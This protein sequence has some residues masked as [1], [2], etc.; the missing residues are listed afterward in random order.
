MPRFV[1]A[2]ALLLACAVAAAPVSA[3]ARPGDAKPIRLRIPAEATSDAL[4]SLA[5]EAG[6]SLGGDVGACQGTSRPLSGRHSLSGALGHLLAGSDCSFEIIDARTV[7]IRRRSPALVHAPAASPTVAPPAPPTV[8]GE[9]VV[10]A[11]RRAELAGRTP[12]AITAIAG[13]MLEQTGNS[14]ISD[15]G[16]MVAGMTVTNLGPGRNK[17]ILRGLSDGTFTGVTQSTVALYLDDVPVT[18][19]APDPDL[20]LIDVDRVEVMR[21]PQGTL[22]GGGSIG[23]IVRIV[24]RKP[25]VDEVSGSA[26]SSLSVTKNGGLNTDLEATLNLPVAPGRVGVRA[27]AYREVDSGYI[28]DVALGLKHANRGQRDGGRL[29]VRALINQDW[30]VQA[31]VVHQSINTR[32]TQYLVGGT[33]SLQ[34]ANQVREPHDNDFDEVYATVN[35]SGSW[36]RV[37]WASAGL[38]HN[39]D[40]RYDATP[41]L[42]TFGVTSGVGAYDDDRT[43]ELLV[44]EITI[45]SPDHGRFRWLAGA[46]GSVGDSHGRFTL[47]VMGDPPPLYRELRTD[48]VD[49]V[50][51]YG[52]ASYDLTRKLNVTAGARW[53]H[54]A[55]ETESSVTQAVGARMFRDNSDS[56]GVSPKISVLYRLNAR[57]LVYGQIAEGYRAGG[58]NTGG[59][60]GQAFDGAPGNPARE[61]A[62][63]ELWNY[64]LGAKL[65]LLSDRLQLRVAGFYAQWSDIQTD[66]FLPSGLPY[67]VNVGDGANRGLELELAWRPLRA[68]DV[69]AAALINDP[70]LTRLNPAFAARRDAGLPGVPRGS[71]SLAVDYTRP[72]WG[73]LDLALHGQLAY[74]GRSRL[75]FDAQDQMGN[76]VTGALSAGVESPRW[77]IRAFVDNPLDSRANTFAFGG[78]FLL[79]RDL[80]R[81]PLRPR[82][83]G[84][85]L[86]ARF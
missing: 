62:P 60:I 43:I 13:D 17:V 32:D 5:L 37:T 58:F 72:L 71:A 68:L 26:S 45:A 82:T 57:A 18:Y 47:G 75:T 40:S 30:S 25:D 27:S 63:D 81:T 12:Y 4:L 56:T 42:P 23:G 80:V 2:E 79:G 65:R 73:D 6:V 3:A 54:F 52:E 28:D 50:A 67:T 59:P 16:G 24:T 41:A 86:G 66:Q 15:L 14:D 53:F 21:G 29:A 22:Y 1:G 83:V 7:M 85:Q 10:T 64:E 8:I 33:D 78:P 61:Y 84:V 35:G 48:Q 77:N 55:F 46:F 70:E 44:S 36:G 51:A 11:G 31:G 69:R 76:Y 39:I 19:N 9:V 74:V 34:R 38:R 20:R 49:E